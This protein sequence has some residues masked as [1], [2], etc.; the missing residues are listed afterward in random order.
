MIDHAKDIQTLVA[1]VEVDRCR[2]VSII[3][4]TQILAM[5]C[6][7][8]KTKALAL[9]TTGANPYYRT[10]SGIILCTWVVDY[11]YLQN[12]FTSYALEFFVVIKLAAIDIKNWHT[13][14]NHLELFA[15][16]HHSRHLAQH[17][18]NRT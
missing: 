14:A 13:L 16:H 6:C 9:R 15:F 4:L 12:F 7:Q 8:V 17:F 1:I 5:S 3:S 18:V 10:H 11:L 2:R